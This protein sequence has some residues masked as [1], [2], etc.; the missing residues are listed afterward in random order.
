M[1]DFEEFWRE[2][3]RKVGRMRAEKCW[4]RMPERDRQQALYSLNLWKQTYQWQ[5]CGGLFIPHGSTFLVQERY[6]DEPWTGA[7]DGK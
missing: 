6:Y 5:S 7:F 3:P 2:Y 4:A 1:I